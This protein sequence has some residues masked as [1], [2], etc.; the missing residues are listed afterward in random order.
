MRI[1][2]KWINIG[3]TWTLLSFEKNDPETWEEYLKEEEEYWG[4]RIYSKKWSWKG[5][6]NKWIEYVEKEYQ[7]H[8]KYCEKWCGIFSLN[9]KISVFHQDE[10]NVVKLCE[11]IDEKID[12]Y[13]T[14]E[15]WKYKDIRLFPTEFLTKCKMYSFGF[16]GKKTENNLISHNLGDYELSFESENS[17]IK[18]INIGGLKSSGE[19]VLR[20]DK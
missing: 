7:D 18:L 13:K 1:D 10:R 15:L 11:V 2:S 4:E 6:R 9:Q 17:I 16:L 5:D 3:K 8:I 20:I 14:I 19:T 12:W